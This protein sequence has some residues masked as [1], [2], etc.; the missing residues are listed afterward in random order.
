MNEHAKMI[1]RID[2]EIEKN[3]EAQRRIWKNAGTDEYGEPRLSSAQKKRM[4]ALVK[5]R[6]DLEQSA[7]AAYRIP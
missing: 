5:E 6:K 2:A 1:S 3:A 4:A 7:N